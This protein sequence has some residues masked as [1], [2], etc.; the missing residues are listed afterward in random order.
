MVE[1]SDTVSDKSTTIEFSM[2]EIM[3][4]LSLLLIITVSDLRLMSF[5]LQAN[6]NNYYR[7]LAALNTLSK[8]EKSSCLPA[9]RLDFAEQAPSTV[10]LFRVITL[11]S[12]S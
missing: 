9:S 8:L 1:I 7:T 12:Q 6:K 11:M 10:E 5:Y 2:S 4:S 3:I